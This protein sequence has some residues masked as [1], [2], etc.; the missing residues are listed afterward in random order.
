MFV[1]SEASH[2]FCFV[3]YQDAGGSANS[4]DKEILVSRAEKNYGREM[5]NAIA[6]LPI[7]H[8][9]VKFPQ[10]YL[11]LLHWRTRLDSGK[12]ARAGNAQPRRRCRSRCPG[13][14]WMC[15]LSYPNCDRP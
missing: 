6:V 14:P 4:T 2:S 10:S 9:S 13:R 11:I 15:C 5:N 8:F 3:T 1:Y 7:G 12:I